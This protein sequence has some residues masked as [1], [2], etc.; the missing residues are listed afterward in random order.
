MVI[1][2]EFDMLKKAGGELRQLLLLIFLRKPEH[3]SVSA[4]WIFPLNILIR[5]ADSAASALMTAFVAYLHSLPF[6]FVYFSRA[7]NSTE[8]V[9]ALSHADVMV[10][11]SQMRF[12]VTLKP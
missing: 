4:L 8:L 6:P 10:Q 12:C 11:D 5:T 2:Y 3:D 1:R 9:G 7:E